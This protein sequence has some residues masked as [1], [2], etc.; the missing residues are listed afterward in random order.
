MGKIALV[1]AALG[2]LLIVS[3]RTAVANPY[4]TIVQR[5]VFALRE[6]VPPPA[7]M[8]LPPQD[9]PE[10]VLTGIADFRTVKWARLTRAEPGKPPRHYTLAARQR[11]DNLEV[12]DINA[13]TDTVRV[14]DGSAEIVLSFD[15]H[16]LSNQARL[17]ELSRKYLQQTK[18]FVDEHV[19]VHTL[20]EQREAERRELERAAAAELAS[21]T[22]TY[23]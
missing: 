8:P 1:Q 6:P 23:E 15:T 2:I 10:L 21:R 3:T 13:D 19:R 14:R 9:T 11:A 12:L 7:P 5:N 20:R 17:E 4:T 18:P 16:G 22:A